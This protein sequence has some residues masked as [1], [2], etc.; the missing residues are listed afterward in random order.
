MRMLRWTLAVTIALFVG[1]G[2]SEP[3]LGQGPATKQAPY[4]RDYQACMKCRHATSGAAGKCSNCGS[5]KVPIRGR[6]VSVC[7]KD[8][9]VFP[10]SQTRCAKHKLDLAARVLT[11]YCASDKSSSSQSGNCSTC[12]KF[13]TKHI[14]TAVTPR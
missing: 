11:Y 13:R 3:I 7:P 2:C 1:F 12:G 4:V 9:E 14:L 5:Q 10:K 8:Q 6:A